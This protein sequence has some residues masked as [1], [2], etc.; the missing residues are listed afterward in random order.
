[1]HGPRY[2][3]QSIFS[4]NGSVW[5]IM[6]KALANFSPGL[7]HQRQPWVAFKYTLNPERVKAIGE[8]LQ[9]SMMLDYK[10]RVVAGAPTLGSI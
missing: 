6:P 10:P 3:K 2:S 5:K 7:E 1:M 8:P 9:G 4:S